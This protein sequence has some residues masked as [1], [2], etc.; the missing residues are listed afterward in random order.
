MTWRDAVVFGG[1]MVGLT[2]FM[3]IL[4]LMMSKDW[5]MALAVSPIPALYLGGFM[6]SLWFWEWAF[7]RDE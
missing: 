2:A 4:A 3:F 6:A 7:P 1:G 5:L